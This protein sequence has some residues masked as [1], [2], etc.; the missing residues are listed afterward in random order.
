MM[1]PT[2]AH[3]YIQVSGLPDVWH[4][5]TSVKIVNYELKPTYTIHSNINTFLLLS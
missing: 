5:D 3:K 1:V 2:N 4:L